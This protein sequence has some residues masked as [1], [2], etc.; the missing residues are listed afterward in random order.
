MDI[1]TTLQCPHTSGRVPPE[2]DIICHETSGP[3]TDHTSHLQEEIK[4]CM[5]SVVSGAD[6]DSAYGKKHPC[7][8]F[9]A[10]GTPDGFWMH[11]AILA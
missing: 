1:H 5:P 3:T 2:S 9:R 6:L 4:A 8:I 10:T 7:A 11:L